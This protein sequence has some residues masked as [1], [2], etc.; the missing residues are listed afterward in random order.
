MPP[1]HRSDAS[2]CRRHAIGQRLR[3]VL[4]GVTALLATP[5]WA[6]GIVI[7]AGGSIT[8]DAGTVIASCADLEIAGTLS[9]GTARL[10]EIGDVHVAPG[11][12]LF[13][14]SASI[15]VG[16]DWA[17]D[18]NFDPQNGTVAFVDGCRSVVS[19]RGTTRFRNLSFSSSS[20]KVFALAAGSTIDVDGTLTITG[21]DTQPVAL[22]SDDL[23]QPVT[24]RLGPA[25]TVT[26]VNA[27]PPAGNVLIGGGA[28][29]HAARVIPTTSWPV[30]LLLAAAFV[31]IVR[32][33]RSLI[34]VQ[35]SG[36]S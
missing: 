4:A 26:I 33:R 27:D 15:E 6:A 16:G 12:N 23:S 13:G 18:G 32:H 11:G 7:P 5:T 20:G 35:R 21:T 2:H 22:V 34:E 9:A 24:I 19:I 1:T 25:A 31:A 30:L 28:A 10:R 29:H 36:L 17:T 8:T 14:G 3:S